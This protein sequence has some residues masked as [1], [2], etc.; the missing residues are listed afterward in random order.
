M[1]LIQHLDCIK[2]EYNQVQSQ[3]AQQRQELEKISIEREQMQR[4][5]MMCYEMSMTMNAEIMKQSEMNKKLSNV[6]QQVIALLPP[7]QATTASAAFDRAKQVSASEALASTSQAQAMALFGGGLGMQMPGMPFM[8]PAA[9]FA[10]NPAFAALAQAN[11]ER[12]NS[13]RP[14]SPKVEDGDSKRRRVDP[15]D[16]EA[17]NID[18]EVEEPSGS[19]QTNGHERKPKSES[20]RDSAHSVA[21]SGASTPGIPRAPRNPFDAL[22]AGARLP[23]I[24]GGPHMIPGLDP[25]AHARMLAAAGMNMQNGARPSYSFTIES[26]VQRPTS[27][28]NDAITAPGMPKNLKKVDELPHGDVVCAVTVAKNKETVFTGGKGCVKV[29]TLPSSSEG[30]SPPASPRSPVYSLGCLGDQY[31][32]SIRLTA[33]STRLYVG[34][35]ASTIAVWDVQ[36]QKVL[37][38]LES[39]VQAVYALCMSP[40][41]KTLFAC[42]S[43]GKVF[44]YDTRTFE[45]MST[46]QGHS[47]GASCVDLSSDGLTLWT[48]G[49]DNTLRAWDIRELKETSKYDFPSQIFSL[50]CSP[51]DDWVAV[52][53][54]SN[55]VEVVSP[56]QA[57]KY[58]MHMHEGCV[59]SLKY[60]QTG[61]FF[62]STGKD[63]AVNLWRSPYGANL[64]NYRETSS[65][66]S[67]DISS[68]ELMLITGSGEKRATVYEIELH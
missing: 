46:L 67:C 66:L 17:V 60:S 9:A 10:A 68:D 62:V 63:N 44:V 32:R 61:N 27:F 19:G 16:E 22:A 33:D 12:T 1:G 35:E 49:L 48:G 40:D 6:L 37:K 45:K 15:D 59:L 53:M 2:D 20:G 8:N 51:K 64:V 31:I 52:G 29:W 47:D 43:D 38:E 14:R 56:S 30:S 34:G 7:E 5:M 26:G 11:N 57:E 39:D 50:S 41:E 25:H 55:I 18:V 28:P 58:S 13:A 54:E 23:Q 24:P 3:L 4:Q 65:V 36:E 42:G 21:S